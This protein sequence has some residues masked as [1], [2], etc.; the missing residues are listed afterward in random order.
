MAN[1]TNLKYTEKHTW[2]KVEGDTATIGITDFAQN[3]LTDIVFVELPDKGKQVQQHKK[4]GIVESVKSVSEI[5]SPVSG[6]VVDVN[7]A[8]KDKATIINK[9]PYGQGWMFKVKLKD[10]K[11]LDSLLSADQYSE[12]TKSAKH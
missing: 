12:S 10:K 11:E 1:P 7:A 4:A 3:Q 8:L 5:F 6:E 2:V 9:D